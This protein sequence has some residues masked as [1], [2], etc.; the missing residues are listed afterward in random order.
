MH[1]M[2]IAHTRGVPRAGAFRPRR[3]DIVL[4][5]ALAILFAATALGSDRAPAGRTHALLINGGSR[6]EANYQSHLH[7][8]ED[9][10]ALLESRGI[11]R[12]R[13][14]IFSADGEEA[15]PDLAVRDTLPPGFRLIEGTAAGRLL[16]PKTELTDTRWHGVTLR[17]AR[18]AELLAWFE[19][20]P[21]TIAPGDRLLLFVTDHGTENTEDPDNGAISLWHESLTVRELRAL[22]DRLPPGV[23]TVMVMSQCYSGTFAG[24]MYEDGSGE[25]SGGVCG[26][27]S[28]TRDL[29][30]YGCYPEGRD[31][32][33]MGHAFHFIDALARRETPVDAHL[34]V[35]ITDDTP[36]VPVRTSDAYLE[37]LVQA[38]AAS[39]E[40]APD[41]LV[42]RLLAGAWRDRGAWEPAI[43][44]LDRL[45]EAF[46]TFSPRSLAEI[47]EQQA[48]LDPLIERMETYTQR[49]RMAVAAVKTENLQAFLDE[50]PDW[51]ERLE[52]NRL[53]TLEAAGRK[54]LLRDLL[55]PLEE[56]AQADAALW[57]RLQDLGE[58]ADRAS[59]SRWRLK[60]RR[61]VLLRMRSILVGIAGR[62]LLNGGGEDGDG[63]DR[64][65]R[66]RAA[67]ER[68]SACEA[69]EP[70]ALPAARIARDDPSVRSF[71]PMSDEIRLVDEVLPSWLGVRFG[72][73]PPSLRAD[74][75]LPQGATMLSA[76][77]PDSPA[78]EAGLQAGD[79]ITG[80]PNSPFTAFGNLR[81]WTMTAPRDT[82][83]RLAVLRAGETPVDDAALEATLRLRPYPMQWPKLPGPPQIGEPAPPLPDGLQPIGRRRLPKTEGRRH[84]LFFWATW[85]GPCKAAVPEVLAFADEE[86]LPVLAISDEDPEVVAAFLEKRKQPFFSRVAADVRRLSYIAYGVSGTP[87]IVVVEKDGIV[88]HR[89]VGYAPKSGLSIEG[90]EWD[91]PG[92]APIRSGRRRVAPAQPPTEPPR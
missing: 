30:A 47:A 27:F 38:E 90:W 20:S 39:R 67:L 85:C 53:K 3:R 21:E 52:E 88:S 72:P 33:R 49:W 82:P 1:G 89:Q 40:V 41:V 25:P 19:R 69:I 60:V 16:R 61:A 46:G 6:P 92:A 83:L 77:F 76:V 37:R 51:K 63:P 8:L 62:V 7:H 28:S 91:A 14:Y 84:L 17:P 12:D 78:I 48:G 64:W 11:P 74:R 10:V 24:A 81:E 79:I 65:A 70:G 56:R 26:F 59:A 54:A 66:E 29:P 35:L 43:R 45:G 36:D 57:S 55:P 58:R 15:E 86:G 22:L 5:P 23:D 71:P 80:P 73:V 68:I 18:E 32:D 87:T 31:R 42:D 9:M 13:I 75:D 50:R 4:S 2:I 44:L 34:E